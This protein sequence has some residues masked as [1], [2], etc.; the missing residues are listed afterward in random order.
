MRISTALM[1]L[2][3]M[4]AG[5]VLCYGTARV[6]VGVLEERSVVGVY[7]ALLDNGH[8]WASVQGDGLQIILE[9]EAPSEAFRF[10][11]M[12]VAGSVVDSSR[13]IDNMQ[14]TESEIITSPDFAI[15]FLRNESGVSMIGLVPAETDRE[16]VT[17]LIDRY[18][19]GQKVTDLLETVEYDTPETWEDSLNFALRALRLLPNSKISM[20]ADSVD[21]RAISGSE[22]ERSE[23]QRELRR[24]IPDG[25]T[26]ALEITAPRPVI[27]PFT[28]RFVKD[29]AGARFDACSASTREGQEAILDAAGTAGAVGSTCDLGLGVPTTTWPDAVSMA[30][31]AI[32]E[33]GGGTL[34]I[35]DADISIV[36]LVGTEHE[37][38]DRVVGKLQNDLPEVFSLK[39]DLPEPPDSEEE[40]PPQFIATLSPEGAAQLRG[41]VSDNLL[42]IT[43]ENYAMARFGRDA[44]DMATLIDEDR[45]PQGWSVRVLTGIE[46]LSLLTNG[47]VV[48]EPDTFVVKG[49]SGNKDARADISRLLIRKIGDDAAF[50]VDVEYVEALDPI[51]AMPTP[52]ECVSKIQAIN[53]ANKI[54]FDPGSTRIASSAL[55]TVEKIADVLRNCPDLPLQISGYTDSQGGEDMNKRL[56]QQRADAVLDALRL[57]RVP[58]RSFTATGFGEEN[59]IA[60]NDTADGREENRRIEFTLVG[61]Q[62]ADEGSDQPAAETEESSDEQN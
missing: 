26:T 49:R 14:V 29:D 22:E 58:T 52:Q 8:D 24:L 50:S 39:S 60:D 5:G 28:V 54:T 20:T 37:L 42:N 45:L 10:R 51:A 61:G 40:G 6:A 62:T 44:V 38:F 56:S 17:K 23:W 27:T 53:A 9:G 32:D 3:A 1:R 12:S 11:A 43:A 59:P 31:G 21:I 33:L 30:I 13:V 36:G 46:A 18:T 15:E 2:G 41:L 34:T 48:V 47:S 57:R 19:D 7:E 35:K 4:V 55:D 25:V 16:D